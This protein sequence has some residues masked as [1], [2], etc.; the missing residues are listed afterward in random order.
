M[1]NVTMQD[2]QKDEPIKSFEAIIINGKG[3]INMSYGGDTQID[4]EGNSATVFLHISG[5]WKLNYKNKEYIIPMSE[6]INALI[7]W[8]NENE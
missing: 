8:I 1:L 6:N 3:M 2:E 7:D 5:D 4:E